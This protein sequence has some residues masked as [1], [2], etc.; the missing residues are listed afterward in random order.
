MFAMNAQS[1]I[2]LRLVHQLQLQ[3]KSMFFLWVP[4]VNP[5]FFNIKYIS[6]FISIPSPICFFKKE[7]GDLFKHRQNLF[8]M[9]I[10]L[11]G[12]MTFLID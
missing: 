6:S 2:T 11:I 3:G 4:L 12:L 10:S 9:N 7:C 1:Q 8:Q 5:P